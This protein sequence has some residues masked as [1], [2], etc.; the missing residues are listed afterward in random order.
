[1]W[2]VHIH[3]DT[4]NV[5]CGAQC[6]YCMRDDAYLCPSTPQARI[7]ECAARQQA[8]IDSSQQT[9]VGVNKY[10]VQGDKGERE[11]RAQLARFLMRAHTH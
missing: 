10:S 5:S 2:Q 9:I 1:M 6:R 3:C 8:R 7:E 11:L 4:L